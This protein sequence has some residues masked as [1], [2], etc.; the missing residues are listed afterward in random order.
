MVSSRMAYFDTDFVF[1]EGLRF[2]YGISA[3]DSNPDPIEDPSI[4]VLRP[5]YKSWGLKPGIRGVDFE[6]VPTR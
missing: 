3:Y 4:G 6:P 2:A 1:S 5:Y